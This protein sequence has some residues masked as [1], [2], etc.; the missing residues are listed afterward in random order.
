MGRVRS[1]PPSTPASATSPCRVYPS[2]MAYS[3]NNHQIIPSLIRALGGGKRITEQFG[4][5]MAGIPAAQRAQGTKQLEDFISLA[6]YPHPV[7][8]YRRSVGEFASAS[9][10]ASVLAVSFV[11][12][13]EIPENVCS[14]QNVPLRG[15][16]VLVLG[17]GRFVTA[18]EVSP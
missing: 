8:D 3:H 9:A 7:I 5:V 2:F 6:E 18:V 12:A 10:V 1:A 16:G 15:R 13:G 14:R 11:N 4:A 17:F